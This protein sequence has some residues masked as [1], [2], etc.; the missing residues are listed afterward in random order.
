MISNVAG[1]IHDFHDSQNM[2]DRVCA[3]ETPADANASQ[4][5]TRPRKKS[6]THHSRCGFMN[7]FAL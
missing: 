4:R 5:E 7:T 1:E 3:R 2:R 6:S